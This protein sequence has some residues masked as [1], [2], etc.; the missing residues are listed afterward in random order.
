M[1]RKKI[2]SFF[3]KIPKITYTVASLSALAA[4]NYSII[5]SPIVLIAMLVI[6]AHE[7]GHY[8]VASLYTKNITP[9]IF[10]PIPFL[11]IAFTKIKDL[12]DH[13]KLSVS[14]AGPVVGFLTILLIILL[15]SIYSFVSYLPLLFML[16]GEIVFNYFGLDGKKYRKA[17]RNT[18][19]SPVSPICV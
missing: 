19:A 18:Y 12:Q 11:I 8:L 14:L 5:H 2:K 13:Q 1:L 15:N 10:L 3:T 17:K 4:L 16:V 7:L 6:L 9:P